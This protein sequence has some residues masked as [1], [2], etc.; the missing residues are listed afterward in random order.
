[1]GASSL[2]ILPLFNREYLW[3]IAVANVIA[4][5]VVYYVMQEWLQGFTYRVGFDP[6]VFLITGGLAVALAIA[7]FIVQALRA[8][9]S[10]PVTTL[11][12]E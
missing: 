4:W 3:L 1:M 8:V 6:V 10:D 11:R 12:Y 9:R 2:D 7:T 5:P